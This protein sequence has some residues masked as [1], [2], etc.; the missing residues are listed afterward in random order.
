MG[1]CNDPHPSPL[2]KG[3]GNVVLRKEEIGN[4]TAEENVLASG[5]LRQ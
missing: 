4:Y 2:P 5:V 1:W 3:E